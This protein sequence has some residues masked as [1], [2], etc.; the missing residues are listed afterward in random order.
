M[1]VTRAERPPAVFLMGPTASGKTAAAVML[2]SRLP[3]EIISVDSAQVYRHMDIGTA[4]PDAETLRIAPH[5][6]IDII[7]PTESYSAARFRHDALA[8]MAEITARGRVPLLVGG[9]MLYFKALREGL[10]ELPE[11]DAALRA[12]IEARARAVGWPQLHAELARLDP[13]TAARLKPTDAQRIQRALEVYAL[14]GEP[15]SRRLAGTAG[16]E[17]FP[18]RV[19][20]IALLPGERSLL[21]RRIAE[22]FEHMLKAG[23]IEEVEWLRAHYELS[24][25]LSS[26]RCVGYRQVWQYLEGEI[27]REALP[28][29]G[30]VATRQLAKRQMTWLRAMQEAYVLDCLDT[31]LEARLFELIRRFLEA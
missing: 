2:A 9:T 19:L 31:G 14:T 27:T 10:S 23:L 5:H 25:R 22:R 6:L 30:I 20:P 28:E 16:R 18:F 17:A 26:M 29:R 13:E 7:E 8:C 15:L 21:H 1:A 24:P 3:V 12:E 11:A 4:K